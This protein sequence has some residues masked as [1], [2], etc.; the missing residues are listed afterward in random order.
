MSDVETVLIAAVARNGIIGQ[1]N[2]LPFKLRSDLKRFKAL[3]TGHPVVMGRATY[4]SIGKPLPGR[5]NVVVSGD[6]EFRADGCEVYDDLFVALERAQ[7]LATGLGKLSLFVI[8]GGQI[9]AQTIDEAD[10]LEITHVDMDTDGDTRF[11]VI[12]DS[13]W[14]VAE[15][16]DQPAGPNDE[17]DMVFVSY[18]RRSEGA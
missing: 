10:R 5:P 13:I 14:Q 8:G 6:R 15:R 7:Q 3:T 16:V 17:A 18:R 12:D 1:A 4:Q 11:P 9:Y 2:D